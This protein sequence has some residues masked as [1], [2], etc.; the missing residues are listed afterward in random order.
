M[1]NFKEAKMTLTVNIL[2]AKSNKEGDYSRLLLNYFE[3]WL[4]Q[5]SIPYENLGVLCE[6]D[7]EQTN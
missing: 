5:R 6:V 4:K 1:K 7:D 3:E 2:M